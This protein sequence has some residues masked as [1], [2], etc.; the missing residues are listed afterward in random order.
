MFFELHFQMAMPPEILGRCEELLQ[1]RDFKGV[2]ETYGPTARFL[3][4][5][6]TTRHFRIAQRAAEAQIDGHLVVR[7]M[8]KKISML[9]MLGTL[10]PMIGLLGTLMGMM[11]AS[12]I[13]PATC[14]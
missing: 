11:K 4:R 9:A 12:V 10:G 8:E 6:L 1:Q 5:L 13:A 3:T 14:S 7:K 2:F